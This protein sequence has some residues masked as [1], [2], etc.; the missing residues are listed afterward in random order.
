VFFVVC[1]ILQLNLLPSLTAAF[2]S[3]YLLHAE[4]F[5]KASRRCK[6]SDIRTEIEMVIF[7][8]YTDPF[9]KGVDRETR[10]VIAS[11]AASELKKTKIAARIGS[12]KDL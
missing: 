10:R 6:I 4:Y 8:N 7:I 11:Y 9:Q 3:T 5:T 12:L 1:L 2:S